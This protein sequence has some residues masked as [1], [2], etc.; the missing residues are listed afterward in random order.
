MMSVADKSGSDKLPWELLLACFGRMIDLH[1]ALA[2]PKHMPIASH[3]TPRASKQ[4]FV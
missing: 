1:H 2:L 4:Q 3:S